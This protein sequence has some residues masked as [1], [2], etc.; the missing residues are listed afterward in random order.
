[1]WLYTCTYTK[2]CSIY[3]GTCSYVIVSYLLMTDNIDSCYNNTRGSHGAH[4]KM[5]LKVE[6]SIM[7]NEI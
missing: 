6:N 1:M 2:S 7:Y 4:L 3:I 5:K